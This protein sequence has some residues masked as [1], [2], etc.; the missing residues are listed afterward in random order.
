[1]ESV[2]LAVAALALRQAVQATE[3]HM[4]LGKMRMQAEA[5]GI[6]QLLEGAARPASNPPHL[7]QQV[8]VRA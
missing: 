7:G 3:L 4:A 2:S 8:D 1:M 5:N 6:V